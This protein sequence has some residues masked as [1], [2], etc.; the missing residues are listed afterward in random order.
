M[1]DYRV[2]LD[3]YNGPLDL[4]L[5]LIRRNEVEIH[6]IPIAMIT[7]Q[8]LAYVEVIKELNI[9]TAGEFLVMAATLTEIKSATLLPRLPEVEQG[10][11]EELGDP[12]LELV[13][14]LLEYKKY[15]D[16]AAEL[17]NAAI[18]QA[19]RY[20]RSTADLQRLQ[21]EFKQQQQ[22]ELDLEGIQIW[23]LFDAFN[24]M[25]AATLAN[26]RGHQV[27]H[28]N[29]PI[30]IYQTDILDRA[31]NQQPLTFEQIFL[32]RSRSEMIGLFL[33]LL[34]LIRE[35]LIRFEQEEVFGPIYLIALTDE[36]PEQAIAHAVSADIDQLPSHLNRDKKHDQAETD[37]SN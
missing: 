7:E 10:E 5:Y 17:R 37:T 35:K 18:D 23:D 25:M 22:S 24:R 1:A 36:P 20:P 31:Q 6:D 2:N 27:I 29:T 9:D 28:D 34:E 33:A 19:Q 14:Q 21:K 32:G 3:I 11:D 15:K 12:R 13:R 26:A 30:D 8:Y 16:A 4:L